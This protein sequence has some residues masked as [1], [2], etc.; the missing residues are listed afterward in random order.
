LKY[1][2]IN[3]NID[4]LKSLVSVLP[5]SPGIYQFF[6]DTDKIIYIGKAKDLKKRV[7]SYFSKSHDHRKT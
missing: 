7:A 2:T 4:Y 6:D 5:N 3:K 1:N